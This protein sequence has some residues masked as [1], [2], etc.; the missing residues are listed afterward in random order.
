[1][2][3]ICGI[4]RTAPEPVDTAEM[5]RMLRMMTYGRCTSAWQYSG[6]Q[7]SFGSVSLDSVR[8]AKRDVY[9]TDRMIALVYGTIYCGLSEVDP[10]PLVP[11]QV[12]TLYE[13]FGDQLWS[14][15][16][17][18][19]IILIWDKVDRKLLIVNDPLGLEPIAVLKLPGRLLFASEVKALLQ[20]R[21]FERELDWGAVANYFLLGKLLGSQ[22]F[23]QDI[24]LLPPASCLSYDGESW[25][26]RKY[27][28]FPYP[29]NYARSPR[30]RYDDQIYSAIREAVRRSLLSNERYGVALSGGLDSRW[31]L[32]C[33][34]ELG[35]DV[36]ACTYSQKVSDDLQI[37]QEVVLRIG[38]T[39]TC[40]PIPEDYLAR[41]MEEIV[42]IS[43]GMFNALHA[44]VFPFVRELADQ[45]DVLISGFSGD[46][47]FGSRVFRGMLSKNR[48][49]KEHAIEF[50]WEG[51][52]GYGL[53]YDLMQE[54]FGEKAIARLREMAKQSLI[55]SFADCTSDYAANLME[56]QFFYNELRRHTY[57][58]ELIK[59]PFVESRYPFTDGQVLETALG[60][61]P[62][63]RFHEQA[64][65]RAFSAHFPDL[66]SIIWEK[67]LLPVSTPFVL[68]LLD[69][70]LRKLTQSVGRKFPRLGVKTQQRYASYGVWMRGPLR[71]YV[72]ESL[73]GS[74]S[75][76]LGV[77]QR[78]GIEKILDI[79]MS[80]KADF[81]EFIGLMLTFETWSRMFYQSLVSEPLSTLV[82]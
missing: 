70:Y 41:Q 42:Y 29:Q 77:F 74:Q 52:L 20:V 4:V 19:F 2:P 18:A 48:S 38:V 72:Y 39:H 11:R 32:A 81:R 6:E 40:L 33:I 3:G 43:D 5:Q 23:F 80:G 30:H 53:P 71:A 61:S 58:T 7:V 45:V 75:N 26:V 34:A 79:H 28:T 51:S 22:T 9:E 36:Q 21:G 14:S 16:S 27:W 49:A 44:H 13:K 50:I 64:Y 78:P 8:L 60:L 54:L 59:A 31:M 37:A 56:C 68:S 35:A 55:D 66:A 73:L 57:V 82:R 12:L 17:G 63:L 10:G 46:L 47:V 62:W 15:L 65:S 69:Y 76:Q 67:T 25:S 24:T 1:M